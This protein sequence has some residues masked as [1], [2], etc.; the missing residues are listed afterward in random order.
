VTCCECGSVAV[1]LCPVSV[2]SRCLLHQRFSLRISNINAQSCSS[3]RNSFHQSLLE[4]APHLFVCER[5][6]VS[7]PICFKTGSAAFKHFEPFAHTSSWQTLLSIPMT[8]LGLNRRV[9]WLVEA[10]VSEKGAVFIFRAEVEPRRRREHASPKRWL[11]PTTPQFCPC[12]AAKCRWIS[13]P[14][15]PSDTQTTHYCI[16]LV[17]GAVIFTPRSLGANVK[18][19]RTHSMSPS[20][21]EL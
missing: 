4:Q 9:D 12:L 16:L 2:A 7:L 13:G 17:L 15:I 1:H 11:L 14:F 10:N 6:R 20:D 5:E 3:Y 19:N 21:L 18:L 8:F